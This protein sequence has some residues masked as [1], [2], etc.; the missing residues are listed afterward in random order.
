MNMQIH[1]YPSKASQWKPMTALESEPLPKTSPNSEI[2]EFWMIV[3]HIFLFF[4]LVKKTV[5][6]QVNFA[7][8]RQWV[9]QSLLQLYIGWMDRKTWALQ[10]K[11]FRFNIRKSDDDDLK[12]LMGAKKQKNKKQIDV[13]SGRT[14]KVTSLHCFHSG[15]LSKVTVVDSLNIYIYMY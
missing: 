8:I 12:Y 1:Q 13:K 14:I 5:H 2:Y 4:F 10:K 3:Q 9:H 7:I 6:S 11:R 15:E